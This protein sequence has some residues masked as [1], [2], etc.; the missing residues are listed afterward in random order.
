[1]IV[2]VLSLFPELF[3]S[4]LST[5]ILGRATRSGHLTVH[6]TDPRDFVAGV[7]SPLPSVVGSESWQ[8]RQIDDT[9]YGGGAGMVIRPEPIVA[10]IEHVEQHR[11]PARKVY[12][13]PAGKPLDQATVVRLAREPRLLLLCGRYEGIDE[14][15]LA[16]VDEELSIGD[17]VLSGGELAALVVIDAVARLQDG[18]LGNQ[19]STVEESFSSGLLEYPHYTRPAEFRGASVPPV[20]I[21]GNHQ[22]IARWRRQQ[23]LCRTRARRPDL[24]AKV[25]LSDDDQRLL[26]PVAPLPDESA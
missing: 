5:S 16:F 14:R 9:P 23:A 13:S 1:M 11:G 6:F 8:R 3:S 25:T 4:V 7:P 22:R 19:Q 12:L 2:E 18:V 10:A 21:S 20:L 24:L 17:Y 26:D 15:A